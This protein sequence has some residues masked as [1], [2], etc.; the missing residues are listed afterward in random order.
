[1]LLCI[2]KVGLSVL[3]LVVGIFAGSCVEL[4]E[5]HIL[6]LMLHFVQ[7]YCGTLVLKNANDADD[8]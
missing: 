5:N 3:L 7:R 4:Y 8:V 1:M 6:G 2:I